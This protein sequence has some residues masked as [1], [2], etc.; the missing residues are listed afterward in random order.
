MMYKRILF[1]THIFESFWEQNN[2]GEE[3]NDD[4]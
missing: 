3:A 2:N 1:G 4:L